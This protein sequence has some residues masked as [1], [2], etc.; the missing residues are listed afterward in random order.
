MIKWPTIKIPL[1]GPFIVILST[2]TTVKVAEISPWIHHS[3]VK[4]ASL[5]WECIPDPAS[6]CR[7]TLW[8]LST[9]PQQDPASQET[10]GDQEQQDDSPALVTS[11][12]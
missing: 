11:G 8:N 1:E 5:K 10:G 6:P 12:S 4:P 7:I 9:L 3:Q 2:P